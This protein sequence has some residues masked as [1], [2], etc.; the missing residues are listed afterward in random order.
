[1]TDGGNEMKDL[2]QKDFW[3]EIAGAGELEDEEVGV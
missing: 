3:S 2:R 1:V